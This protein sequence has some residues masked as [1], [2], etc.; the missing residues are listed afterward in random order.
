MTASN[1][2]GLSG[3]VIASQIQEFIHQLSSELS[4]DERDVQRFARETELQEGLEAAN[5]MRDKA[6]SVETG[7]IIGGVITVASATGEFCEASEF[8]TSLSDVPHPGVGDGS[9]KELEACNG[10]VNARVQGFGTIANV[11]NLINQGFEAAGD[12]EAAL[13][14]EADARSRAAGK[15]ADEADTNLRAIEKV[16]DSGKDLLQEIA[17]EQHSS[18]MA[19]LARR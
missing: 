8:R 3:V 19:I 6:A 10:Q 13:S 11:G 4:K 2:N 12:R 1:T 7:A 14:Q 18:V 5:K 15:Q 9:A 17:R 16:D